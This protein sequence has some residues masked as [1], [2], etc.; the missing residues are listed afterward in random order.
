MLRVAGGREPGGRGDRGAARVAARGKRACGESEAAAP[1][2]HR[3]RRARIPL[4]GAR[5][6]PRARSA[7][8]ARVRWTCR[9]PSA[10]CRWH[11]PNHAMFRELH[12]HGALLPRSLHLCVRVCVCCTPPNLLGSWARVHGIQSCPRTA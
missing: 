5:A 1:R 7:F 4:Q 2:E 9:A 6:R 10:G 11:S 3:A 8:L 12:P